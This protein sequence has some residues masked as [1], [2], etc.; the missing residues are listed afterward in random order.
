MSENRPSKAC[1]RGSPSLLEV[2]PRGAQASGMSQKAA[3][4]LGGHS[5]HVVARAQ[6]SP[7]SARGPSAGICSAEAPLHLARA[8]ESGPALRPSCSPCACAPGAH[9]TRALSVRSSG[10]LSPPPPQPRRLQ[11][12]TEGCGHRSRTPQGR[13]EAPRRQGGE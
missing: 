7:L 12:A 13:S 5:W 11:P 4:T 3:R 10:W 2:F 8:P 1:G 9:P 6:G